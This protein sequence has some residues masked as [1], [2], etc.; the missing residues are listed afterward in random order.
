MKV[1]T[2]AFLQT[3]GALAVMTGVALLLQYLSPKYG[4]VVYFGA[5]AVYMLYCLTSIR[6]NMMESEQNRIIDELKK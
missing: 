2:K 6:A 3:V 4:M 5:L 1:R